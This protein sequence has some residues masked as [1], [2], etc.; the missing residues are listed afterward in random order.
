MSVKRFERVVMEIMFTRESGSAPAAFLVEVFV[1][2]IVVEEMIYCFRELSLWE[3]G[4]REINS[5]FDPLRA[6]N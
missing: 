5:E 4:L 1:L 2:A 6:R 3:N